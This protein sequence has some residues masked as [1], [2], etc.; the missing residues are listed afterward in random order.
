[1]ADDFLLSS[2]EI[3]AVED[4]FTVTT[5]AASAAVAVATEA[6]IAAPLTVEAPA[7]AAVIGLLHV[8]STNVMGGVDRCTGIFDDLLKGQG[9]K[10]GL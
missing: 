10:V 4:S 1:M 5:R 3:V 8:A 7:L 2:F 9:R 6:A